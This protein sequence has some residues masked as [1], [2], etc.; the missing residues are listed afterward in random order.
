MVEMSKETEERRC[1]SKSE[2]WG[3]LLESAS[4]YSVNSVRKVRNISGSSW[5]Q[6]IRQEINIQ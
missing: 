4:R 1:M 2:E 3:F 6:S 5:F